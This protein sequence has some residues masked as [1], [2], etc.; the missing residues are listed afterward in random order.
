M[1]NIY[2]ART[3]KESRYPVFEFHFFKI[4]NG[5]CSGQIQ[6]NPIEIHKIHPLNLKNGLTPDSICFI[7]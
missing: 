5:E 4:Q 3:N 1:K 2:Y 6:L 7:N